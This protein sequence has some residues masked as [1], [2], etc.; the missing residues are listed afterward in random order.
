MPS[1]RAEKPDIM[2][3]LVHQGYR[4][5][6]DDNANEVNQLA[7][8]FPE[9]DVMLGGHLHKPLAGARLNGVLYSQAGY[10]G[11]WLGRVDLVFDTVR[12]KVVRKNSDVIPIEDR[13]KKSPELN[14]L[15]RADLDKTKSYLNEDLGFA[16]TGLV[17]SVKP[18]A[19]SPIQQLICK[20]IV[21]A[22]K[23]DIWLC[24]GFL[25]RVRSSPA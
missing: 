24:T 19:Q 17:A 12:K 2:V 1:V 3:L 18:P 23:A 15:L 16:E 14:K 5:P 10:Y 21:Q 4:E 11:N 20:S 7:R 25:S 22:V 9:F 13:L 8:S 6:G